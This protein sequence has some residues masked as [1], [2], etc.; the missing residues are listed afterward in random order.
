VRTWAIGEPSKILGNSWLCQSCRKQVMLVQNLLSWVA[1]ELAL[2][3][4]MA[5]RARSRSFEREARME[6]F[7]GYH[8]AKDRRR[9]WIFVRTVSKSN[10]WVNRHRYTVS[11]RSS[12]LQVSLSVSTIQ[13]KHCTDLGGMS[14]SIGFGWAPP[15]VAVSR[16][17]LKTWLCSV[18]TMC[19]RR[20]TTIPPGT[21]QT[22]TGEP[23]KKAVIR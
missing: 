18:S 4:L 14:R 8:C 13:S 21:S 20:T 1:N 3:L 9:M 23:E 6:T 7:Q 19:G 17:S 16:M 12:F 22:P 2:K 15:G 11:F 5:R 10:L